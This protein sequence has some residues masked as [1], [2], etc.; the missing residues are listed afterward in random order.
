[1]LQIQEITA[2]SE[3]RGGRARRAPSASGRGRGSG[4]DVREGTAPLAQHPVQPPAVRP[5][6]RRSL[7]VCLTSVS[8]LGLFVGPILAKEGE[9]PVR[10]E[11]K[12]GLPTLWRTTSCTR[13]PSLKCKS[14]PKTPCFPSPAAATKGGATVSAHLQWMVVQNGSSVL[15]KRKSQMYGTE[16]SNLK[17]RNSFRYN[18]LIHRK[19][20]GVEPAA[21]GK[22]L[23][24][25]TKQRSSPRKLATCYVR[26]SNNKNARATLT[27][28][29]HI[30]RNKWRP[31]LRM[32]ALC[33][34]SNVLR[35]QK[36]VMV[37]RKRT[38]PAK[39]S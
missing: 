18:E 17:A 19:A 31:D 39:S 24:A 2:F 3:D 35:S 27:S 37:P 20:V 28:I 34:A 12:R 8:A 1:M 11:S 25:V 29:W 5:R 4:A 7:H 26:T 14:H 33:R 22:G 10:V 21:A 13:N 15:I 6:P 16:P 38:H 30:I 32:A 9:I 36:P 23:V